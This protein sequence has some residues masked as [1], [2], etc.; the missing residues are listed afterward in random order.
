MESGIKRVTEDELETLMADAGFTDISIDL[1]TVKRYHETPEAVLELHDG[2]FS[3]S[4]KDMPEELKRDIERDI[5]DELENR[6]R[7][8]PRNKQNVRHRAGHPG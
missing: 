4:M 2:T 5:L 1:R 3:G 6:S 8:M 7:L